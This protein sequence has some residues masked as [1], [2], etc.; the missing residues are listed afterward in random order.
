MAALAAAGLPFG[1]LAEK[2]LIKARS[3]SMRQAPSSRYA[4]GRAAA[5]RAVS[6]VGLEQVGIGRELDLVSR[7]H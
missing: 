2:R 6:R 4:G 5:L 1:M 7:D 3:L